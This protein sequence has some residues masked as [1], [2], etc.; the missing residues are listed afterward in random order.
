MSPTICCIY[1]GAPVELN[2]GPLG[3]TCVWPDGQHATTVWGDVFMVEVEEP[4]TLCVTLIGP[5]GDHV[6]H[7][8]ESCRSPVTERG[9]EEMAS[10]YR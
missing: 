7:W 1:R 3:L 6:K 8:F 10:P 5:E 9:F 4:G 2:V